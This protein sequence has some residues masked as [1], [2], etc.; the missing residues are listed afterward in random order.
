MEV[1][2]CDSAGADA[3]TLIYRTSAGAIGERML[4]RDDEARLGAVAPEQVIRPA[5]G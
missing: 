2:A 1:V 5:R 4:L 3:V